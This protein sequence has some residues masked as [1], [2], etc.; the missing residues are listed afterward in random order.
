MKAN[1]I[2]V[3]GEPVCIV[4]INKDGVKTGYILR[5]KR[6]IQTQWQENRH[7]CS[8]TSSLDL[9]ETK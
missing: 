6:A 3:G 2:T 7:F 8:Q 4:N 1:A 5:G 9:Y